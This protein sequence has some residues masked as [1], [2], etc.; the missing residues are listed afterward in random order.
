LTRDVRDIDYCFDKLAPL[1]K[2]QCSPDQNR[3]ILEMLRSVASAE[4]QPGEIEGA[5]LAR[6]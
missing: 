3:D 5:A 1:I 2:R 4:G 6:V